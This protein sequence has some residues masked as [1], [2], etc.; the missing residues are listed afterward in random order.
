MWPFEV[1]SCLFLGRQQEVGIS[2]GLVVG[3]QQQAFVP[4]DGVVGGVLQMVWV[5]LFNPVIVQKLFAP[6]IA[7]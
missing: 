5:V 4:C 1:A 7:V 2:W 6:V 3:P